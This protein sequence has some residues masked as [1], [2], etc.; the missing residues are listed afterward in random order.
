MHYEFS[1]ILLNFEAFCHSVFIFHTPTI[2]TVKK[3]N[4]IFLCM[5]D[6]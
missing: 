2:V 6:H 1:V 3:N 5:T 4:D